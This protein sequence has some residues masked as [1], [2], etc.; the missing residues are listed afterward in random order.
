MVP[1][2]VDLIR[3]GHVTREHRGS[4]D[5]RDRH[6]CHVSH[7]SRVHRTARDLSD[8]QKLRAAHQRKSGM[9]RESY[10]QQS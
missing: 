9:L 1:L 4:R 7:A 3:A 10:R 2:S 8:Q 5:H 6:V